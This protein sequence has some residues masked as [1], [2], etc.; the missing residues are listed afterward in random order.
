MLY[1]RLSPDKYQAVLF[2]LKYIL[3][4]VGHTL[5]SNFI[6][7]ERKK[8]N[9]E[10]K[11][12]KDELVK[13]R[14][15]NII[16]KNSIKSV[17][18][19]L[20]D[21]QQYI[22]RW[23]IEIS[24]IPTRIPQHDL[25]KHVA[26]NILR[27]LGVH[28]GDNDIDACHRL[29]KRDPRKPANVVVRFVNRKNAVDAIKNRYLLKQ[30]KCLF[31]HYN[32][33][34]SYR[35]ILD[36][37]SNLRK[38]GI[39]NQVWTYNGKVT[40]KKSS[41]RWGRGTRIW[42]IDELESLQVESQLKHQRENDLFPTHVT[43]PVAN[44]S[45]SMVSPVSV[46]E[47]SNLLPS[48][49]S[50][51]N[52]P[53]LATNQ[54]PA[55]NSN[56]LPAPTVPAE[57]TNSSAAGSDLLIPLLQSVVASS[58]LHESSSSSS[59]SSNESTLTDPFILEESESILNS[60]VRSASTS[61]LHSPAPQDISVTIPFLCPSTSSAPVSSPNLDPSPSTDEIDSSI[62]EDEDVNSCHVLSRINTKLVESMKADLLQMQIDYK[63][64]SPSIFTY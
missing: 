45:S 17:E 2:E 37:L 48:S 32:L 23:S 44:S 55:A 64:K 40:Y 19:D 30:H 62:I 33:C 5:L 8:N 9:N 52:V 43:A 21:L 6:K 34:P 16:L 20:S 53:G 42:H 7:A 58:S 10:F 3:I 57:E 24:G 51:S 59:I 47:T 13:V 54:A 36:S 50:S 39:V 31:I 38:E 26:E 41:N 29:A 27:P 22:R 4:I 61:N 14:N 15:A 60:T 46:E 25:E 56:S 12:M 18:K 11:A 63:N 28:V 1:M 35:A 49:S